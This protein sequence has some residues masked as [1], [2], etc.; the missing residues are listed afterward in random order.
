MGHDYRFGEV[1]HDRFADSGPMPQP[2]P[3]VFLLVLGSRDKWYV[4]VLRLPAPDG[5]FGWSMYAAHR[6]HL[7][8]LARVD[9]LLDADGLPVP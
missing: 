1:Y 4:N 5:E 6:A 8:M 3:D 7:D 2:E 9:M